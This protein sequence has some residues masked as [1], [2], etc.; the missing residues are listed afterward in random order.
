VLGVGRRVTCH[1]VR[2]TQQGGHGAWV[3]ELVFV[4]REGGA[5]LMDIRIG[6]SGFSYDDWVGPFYPL[7]AE[8]RR[9]LELYA[10]RFDTVEI[11]MTYYRIPAPRM[12]Q[13]WVDRT[14]QGFLFT[15]K[16]NQLMTHDTENPEA[17]A[18]I[19]RF[20]E[21]IEP[22]VAADRLGCVLLQF[23]QRLR[24][25][26]EARDH[27][28]YLISELSPLP[29]V[30]EFRHES[31]SRETVHRWLG[32]RGVG[33]CCVDEPELPGLMP[34]E[35]VVTGGL[36]YLRFHG[37]NAAK[38]HEHEEASERYDY[39]YAREE[40]EEWVPRVREMA[41]SAERML[42]YFNNHRMGQAPDNAE[43]FKEL[44]RLVPE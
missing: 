31:W 35:T 17:A 44:L 11:N 37:R 34:R 14:P 30:C 13:G 26:A 22:L 33:Y 18:A 24:P 3:S 20:R 1:V 41:G 9:F 36:G 43:V 21:A 6:C 8:S 10:E 12:V 2:G 42:V 38:W 28:A 25:T 23:P 5:C 40:L 4:M 19:P 29:L 16:G 7:G 15:V 27:I 32:S 39:R